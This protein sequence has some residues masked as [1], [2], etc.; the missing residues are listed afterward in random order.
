VHV[1]PEAQ[2]VHPVYVCPPHLAPQRQ[3][4]VRGKDKSPWTHC[5]HL[6]TVQPLPPPEVVVVVVVVLVLVLVEFV[7]EP[8]ALSTPV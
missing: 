5:P 1:E 4:K 8:I 3:H 6:A 7:P 2:V